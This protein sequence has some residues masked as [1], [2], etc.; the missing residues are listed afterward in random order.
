[1]PAN[2]I[3]E[4]AGSSLKVTGSSRATVSAGPMPGRTPTAV[5]SITP[6]N[7]NNRLVGCSAMLS[8]CPSAASASISEQ[9]LDRP[10]RQR[11]GQELGEHQI[12]HQRQHE[13]DRKIGK[14][15]AAAERCG[16]GGKQYRG[17]RNESAVEA[18]DRDQRRQTTEN[19]QQRPRVVRLALR[20][21]ALP[22]EIRI[23][24]REQN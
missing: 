12:D 15:G 21:I 13:S 9:P 8:P 22:G 18:D 17:R 14:D 10:H 4:P 5:P 2:M 6:I 7:A 1:M 19:Q 23:A 3:S 24:D 16:G 11:Q 20:K